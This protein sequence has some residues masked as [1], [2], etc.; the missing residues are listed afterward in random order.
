MISFLFILS[1]GFIHKQ[2][3]ALTCVEPPPP[4]E[5]FQEYDAVIVGQVTAI[6]EKRYVKRLTVDVLES[7]Q[8]VDV[9]NLYVYEDWNWGESSLSG[10]YLFYMNEKN[11]RYEV[12]LCSPTSVMTSE[13]KD[14]LKN[15]KTIPLKEVQ[16]P[17]DGSS[18]YLYVSIASVCIMILFI[19]FAKRKKWL[20]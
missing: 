16:I 5:A 6:H 18:I 7:Y 8:Y 2:T 20:S 14:L 13:L 12:P 17:K 11:G 1:F 10:T 19:I 15:N 9:S 4:L 3:F